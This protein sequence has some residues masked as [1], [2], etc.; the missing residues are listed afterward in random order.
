[1]ESMD[2]TSVLQDAGYADSRAHPRSQVWV[3]YNII[4]YTST[5]INCLICNKDIMTIVLFFKWWG[6]GKAGEGVNLC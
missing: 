3:E 5:S 2:V 6:D 4:S 1:M